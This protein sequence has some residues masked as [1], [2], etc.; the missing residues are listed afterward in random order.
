MF[1]ILLTAAALAASALGA[2]A[3]SSLDFTPIGKDLH[4]DGTL[5]KLVFFRSGHAGIGRLSL[6]EYTPPWP[7]TGSREGAHM[8]VPGSD[9]TVRLRSLET[10]EPLALEDE[11]AVV[12]W[13]KSLMPTEACRLKV[14][15]LVKNPVRLNDHPTLEVTLSYALYGRPLQVSLFICQRKDPRPLELFV[16]EVAAKPEHFQKA[17]DAFQA[18]LYTIVGF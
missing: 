10:A 1:R 7:I 11:A 2:F 14:E 6:V 13:V 18:S 16:F 5:R 9:A 17:H 8:G 12:A 15:R 4:Y 3:S